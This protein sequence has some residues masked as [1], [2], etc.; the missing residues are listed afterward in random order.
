MKEVDFTDGIQKL[1]W[2]MKLWLSL[3]G[4]P[5]SVNAMAE[6]KNAKQKLED[7]W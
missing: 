7:V 5:R 1:I 2:Q 3:L 4:Q 6:L